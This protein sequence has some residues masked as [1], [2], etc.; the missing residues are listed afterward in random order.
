M[1]GFVVF[2]F[3]LYLLV[4]NVT[5]L[6]PRVDNRIWV[7]RNRADAFCSINHS[8]R[9]SWSDG[10]WPQIPT[11]LPALAAASIAIFSIA[12]TAGLRSSNKCNVT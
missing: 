4:R 11:Y 6:Q 5:K 3:S 9:S 12:L 8:A 10:P 2:T 1:T 7:Q